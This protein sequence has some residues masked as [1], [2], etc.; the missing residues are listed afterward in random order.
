MATLLDKY[1]FIDI[2]DKEKEQAIKDCK[3]VMITEDIWN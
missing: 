3:I 1:D 2:K